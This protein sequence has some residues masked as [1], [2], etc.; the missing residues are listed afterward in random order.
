MKR[1]GACCLLQQ[2]NA[3]ANCCGS[4]RRI[5]MLLLALDTSTYQSSIAL[6]SEEQ[7]YGEYTWYSANNH[8]V[9]L[10]GNVQRLIAES[11]LTMQQLDA[12][13]VASGPGSFNGVRVALAT[14]KAL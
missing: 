13:A 7:L 10:L 6:C 14:A 5:R 3:I 1:S 9:E 8:S 11:R 4:F 2:A 12:I